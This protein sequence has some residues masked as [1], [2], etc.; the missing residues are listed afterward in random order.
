MVAERNRLYEL[1]RARNLTQEQ[2]E[3]LSGIDQATI[4]RLENHELD[5]PNYRTVAALAVVLGV[6]AELLM[7][8]TIPVNHRHEERRR[9]R[10]RRQAPERRSGVDRRFK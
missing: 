4:S 6:S 7:G 9:G 3:D 1:R 5:N 10:V 2:L 8:E